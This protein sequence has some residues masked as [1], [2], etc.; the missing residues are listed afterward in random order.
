MISRRRVVSM[1]TDS[2]APGLMI[3]GLHRELASDTDDTDY[4]PG[5]REDTKC[6]KVKKRGKYAAYCFIIYLLLFV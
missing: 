5:K 1:L 4:E 3:Y 6:S 2:G